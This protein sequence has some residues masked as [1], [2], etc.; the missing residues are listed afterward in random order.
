MRETNARSFDQ[1]VLQASQQR[2]VLVDVSAPWCA[3]CNALVPHLEA[4]ATRYSGRMDVLKVNGDNDPGLVQAYGVRAYPTLLLFFGGQVI[5]S[6]PG[7]PGSLSGLLAFVEPL[8][9]SAPV[10]TGGFGGRGRI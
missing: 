10:Q 6:H 9:G 2:P 4:L 1:D 8:P 5:K 7:S 3:P